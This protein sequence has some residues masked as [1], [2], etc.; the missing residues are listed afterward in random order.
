[1][2]T[3]LPFRGFSS[4]IRRLVAYAYGHVRLHS[5]R[6]LRRSSVSGW[7]IVAPLVSLNRQLALGPFLLPTML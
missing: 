5:V 4:E 2:E 7:G 3:D 1:M 6:G